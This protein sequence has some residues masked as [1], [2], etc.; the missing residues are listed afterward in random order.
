MVSPGA[1]LRRDGCR[2][3]RTKKRDNLGPIYSMAIGF[4]FREHE[5]NKIIHREEEQE[6]EVENE[7]RRDPERRQDGKEEGKKRQPVAAR[8]KLPF[9]YMRSCV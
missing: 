9:V 2:D 5:R 8:V 6:K 4:R 3:G 1:S 7:K